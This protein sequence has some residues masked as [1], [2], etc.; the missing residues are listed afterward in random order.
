MII[1]KWVCILATLFEHPLVDLLLQ[2]F[3]IVH[4]SPDKI[5]LVNYG[6]VDG[7]IV[8]FILR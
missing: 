4:W 1:Y 5:A 2:R 3:I 6:F 7:S 8:G